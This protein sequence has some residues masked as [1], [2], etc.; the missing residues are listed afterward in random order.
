MA[1]LFW[2]GWTEIDAIKFKD[3]WNVADTEKL[4]SKNVSVDSTFVCKHLC[5]QVC[6]YLCK[7]GVTTSM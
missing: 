1:G 6:T 2:F 4:A 3:G 7:N 5:S